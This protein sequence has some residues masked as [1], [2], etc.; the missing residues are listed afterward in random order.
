MAV[1]IPLRLAGM[2]ASAR[3]EDVRLF[4]VFHNEAMVSASTTRHMGRSS[5]RG[6]GH[7]AV[8]FDGGVMSG[9]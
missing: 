9:R 7:F 1:F 4:V 5:P 2:V 8:F 3:D 6:R